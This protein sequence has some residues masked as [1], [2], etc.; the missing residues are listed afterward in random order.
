MT[1]L[2][3]KRIYKKGDTQEAAVFNIK[4]PRMLYSSYVR[5]Q[6]LTFSHNLATSQ[7]SQSDH[8]YHLG[9]VKANTCVLGACE[10]S[11]P[12]LCWSCCVIRRRNALSEALSVLLG[13]H[14]ITDTNKWLVECH[15]D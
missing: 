14:E 2:S 10:T 13:I 4:K 8:S 5:R 6:V 12:H 9:R 15:G 3:N 1:L 7:L 11:Q